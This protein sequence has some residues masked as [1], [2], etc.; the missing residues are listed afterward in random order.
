MS[1]SPQIERIVSDEEARGLTPVDMFAMKIAPKL[2]SQVLRHRSFVS[3]LILFFLP[4]IVV[5][6]FLLYVGL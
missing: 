5:T 2:A 1:E 6:L 4:R 3:L